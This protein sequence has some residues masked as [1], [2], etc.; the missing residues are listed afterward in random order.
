MGLMVGDMAGKASLV[1]GV[2]ER[3]GCD[4]AAGLCTTG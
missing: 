3:R 4:S 1:E 2:T